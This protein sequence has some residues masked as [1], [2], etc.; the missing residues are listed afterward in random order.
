MTK[1]A[2]SVLGVSKRYRLFASPQERVKEA[3]HPFR[4]TYHREFWALRNI[5]FEIVQGETVGILGRNGSGKST[6][7][8]L[9]CSVSSPTFGSVS[10]NGR[11]AAL[12]ELG[13]GFNPQF[14][15]RANVILSGTIMGVPRHEMLKRLPAIEAFADVGHFFDQPVKTYSSGMFV[16][17]AFAVAINVDPD[18]LVIDEAL[19][20]GDAKFQHKC[21]QKFAEFKRAGKTIIVVSHALDMIT[22]HCDRAL[23]IDS[24]H[25]ISDGGPQEVVDQYIK[26]VFG[27]AADD[28]VVPAAAD[29]ARTTEPGHTSAEEASDFARFCDERVTEPYAERRRTYNKNETRLHSGEVEILDYIVEVNGAVDT[30]TVPQNSRVSVWIKAKFNRAVVRP[31]IGFSVKSMNGLIVYGSNTFMQRIPVEHV[32]AGAVKRF[33]FSFMNNLNAGDY[34]IDIGVAEPDG[35]TGGRPLDVRRSVAHFTVVNSGPP[36]F[37]GLIDLRPHFS[38][39]G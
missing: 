16:R 34:F 39:A 26:L 12:L 27:P 10:V 22:A 37:E 3:L 13:A 14:T 7:L 30:P 6:L 29:I 33:Q 20:V 36:A 23:L 17:V 9:I 24:G 18:I 19:A 8:Q 38:A 15:G 1:I 4:R 31:I 35:T 2:L 32:A 28:N 21:F 25:L 11:I 5:T